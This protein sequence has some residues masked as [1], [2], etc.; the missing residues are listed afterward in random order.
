MILTLCSRVA[1]GPCSNA[2]FRV[3]SPH[4]LTT[5]SRG[6][7]ANRTVWRPLGGYLSARSSV[8][9]AARYKRGTNKLEPSL[10]GL[11]RLIVSFRSQPRV[12]CEPADAFAVRHYTAAYTGDHVRTRGVRDKEKAPESSASAEYTRCTF[13]T[14]QLYR[15]YRLGILA[16]SHTRNG[17]SAENTLPR[18]RFPQEHILTLLSRAL[19]FLPARSARHFYLPFRLLSLR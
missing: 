9:A 10:R 2:V 11:L 12:R 4:A 6:V 14:N 17:R 8:I 5:R 13:L 3:Y 19:Y 16:F 1:F 18:R 7:F 15:P